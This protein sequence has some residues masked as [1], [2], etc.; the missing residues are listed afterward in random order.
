MTP[1]LSALLHTIQQL[2]AASGLHSVDVA[3]LGNTLLDAGHRWADHGFDRL[4]EA[5]EHLE[6]ADLVET[7]RNEKGSLR[8]RATTKSIVAPASR[9][10]STHVTPTA[11]AQR[12]RPLRSPIWFA[13][14]AA[15][16]EGGRRLL[17]RRDGTVW[18]DPG[19]PPGAQNDWVA[20]KPV[21]QDEQRDWAKQF[22]DDAQIGEDRQELVGSL[23]PP[24]WFRRFPAA[25][26]GRGR[27]L[28]RDWNHRRSERIIGYVKDWAATNGVP[29]DVL[30]DEA[31]CVRQPRPTERAPGARNLRESLLDAVAEMPTDALLELPIPARLVIR[32]VRPDLLWQ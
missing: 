22:L 27:S 4:S 10:D 30:F 26:A 14:I 16:A 32:A 13:F 2:Q 25:L 11:H 1:F 5:L 18:S 28:V 24:D 15:L 7:F 6:Q 8:V 20:V 17:N 21:D 19:D 29:D 9:L 31:P 3:Y 23:E 12:F